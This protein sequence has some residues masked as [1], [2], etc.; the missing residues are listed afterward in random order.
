MMSKK[1]VTLTDQF[2]LINLRFIFNKLDM[3]GSKFIDDFSLI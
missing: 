3:M 2:D 1:T